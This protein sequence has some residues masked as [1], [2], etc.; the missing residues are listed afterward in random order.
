M[1]LDFGLGVFEA[2]YDFLIGAGDG[3]H[4]GGDGVGDGER[5][6]APLP[7]VRAIC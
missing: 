5:I 2:E 7:L 3:L 4:G 6:L 1:V